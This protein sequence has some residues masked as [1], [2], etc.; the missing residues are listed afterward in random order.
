MIDPELIKKNYTTLINLLNSIKLKYTK[1]R[2]TWHGVLN[3]ELI[4]HVLENNLIG[5]YLKELDYIAKWS[6]DLIINPKCEVTPTTLSLEQPYKASTEDGIMLANF[7]E[8]CLRENVKQK[9]YFA[10]PINTVLR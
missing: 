10:N 8:L 6:N 9:F 7:F 2:F 1:V 4:K 5:D 3:F